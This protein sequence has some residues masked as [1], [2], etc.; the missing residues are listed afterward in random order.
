M[1]LSNYS[2]LQTAVITHAMRTGDTEFTA[3]V[4]D[5]VKLAHTRINREFRIRDMEASA[6][7]TIASGEGDLPSGYLEFISVKDASGNVLKVADQDF[8]DE[9][10]ANAASGTSKHFAIMGSKIKTWPASSSNLTMRYYQEIE[11]LATAVSGT[12]WLLTK[13][14]GVYLYGTLAEAAVFMMDDARLQVWAALYENL[15]RDLGN[16][17]F[18]AK[19][20]RSSSRVSGPT[21]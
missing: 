18:M 2:E 13:A 21:P 17:N 15:K 20:A 14:P 9:Q 5:M 7:I 8:A 6:T 11:D 10:Y 19:Y 1:A 16:E 4:P 3:S 12:N